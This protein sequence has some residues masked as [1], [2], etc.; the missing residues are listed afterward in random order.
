MASTTTTSQ[1]AANFNCYWGM[2]GSE[3][4]SG[5][6]LAFLLVNFDSPNSIFVSL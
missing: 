6:S 2:I 1:G 3:D 4:N 5:K